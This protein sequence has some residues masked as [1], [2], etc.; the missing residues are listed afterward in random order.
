MGAQGGLSLQGIGG[1]PG[2]AVGPAYLVDRRRGRT[3]KLRLSPLEIESE[4]MRVKTANE[5]ADPP[6]SASKGRISQGEGPAH[7][8]I[9][10]APP[11]VVHAPT[12][13]PAGTK[14]ISRARCHA[15]C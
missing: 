15:P 8:L 12:F 3:P 9:P 5:L 11:A 10:E 4:L 1:S 6:L 2:I 7:P 14:Q 13:P